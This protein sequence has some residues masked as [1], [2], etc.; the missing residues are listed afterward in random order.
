VLTLAALRVPIALDRP[1]GC[2][3][4][5]VQAMSVRS[6]WYPPDDGTPGKVV[7][8][9]LPGGLTDVATALAAIA[10]ERGLA[11]AGGRAHRPGVLF[12]YLDNDIGSYPHLDLLCAL[13]R[14]VLGVR[15]RIST[16]GYSSRSPRLTA[17][18]Q[19]IATGYGDVLDG[20]RLSV[21]PYTIG[22]RAGT[23]EPVSRDQF[24]RDTAT[25]LATYRP[26]LDR[27]GHG[28]ATAAAELRFA[29]LAGIAELTD[30][31]IGGRHALACGPH[32]LI[33]TGPHTGPLPVTAVDRLDS[34]GQPVLSTPGRRYLHL[35]SD[36][37]SWEATIRQAVAG[38]L[39]ARHRARQVNLFRFANADGPYYAADP[40]F[41][42]DGRFTALHLYPATRTRRRA[43]YT[44]ATR[45]FLNALLAH[46]AERGFGPRDPFTAATRDDVLAI[47]ARLEAT[48]AEL[49]AGIDH[50]ATLHVR[51]AVIPLVTG[52]AAALDQADYPPAMLFSPSFTIDTGQIVNQG[53]ARA[54]FRGLASLDDEPMTPREERGY[55]QVSLS[56]A[57]GTIWR[58]APAPSAPGSSLRPAATGGKNTPTRVPSLIVEELDPRHLRPVMRASGTR[59]RRYAI[60]GIDLERHTLDDARRLHSY[61]G[62]TVP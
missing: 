22:W 39:P 1:L 42:H 11:I 30:T 33:S 8:A 36:S 2:G 49:A 57:R 29:P 27:L 62:L 60:T 46:K 12:P 9:V 16:V 6:G 53:R 10:A 7:Y 18:H 47:L 45:W 54:L 41:H 35:T 38:Q 44:D 40:G 58:I 37:L 24:T 51:E 25:M 50:A 13:A 21:T 31:V 55:G 26:L 56:S 19:R 4:L 3:L 17:M 5:L 15:L 43:G 28:A 20:I 48:A 61:P 52:Y 23:R 34:R 59:L 32:L 14:D